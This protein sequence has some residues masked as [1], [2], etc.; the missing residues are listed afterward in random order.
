VHRSPQAAA[1]PE[2][3]PPQ[4]AP[5]E[6][7]A[8]TEAAPPEEA[9][10]PPSR[11]SLRLLAGAV[12]W[13]AGLTDSGVHR[14]LDRLEVT[15]RRGRRCVH[16]P[17]PD[18][19][20]KMA[21]VAAALGEARAEPEAVV[22]LY[23]DELTFYRRPTVGYDYAARGGPCPPARQ[24]TG[25]NTKRRVIGALDAV[26]G[27]LTALLRSRA[28]VDALIKFYKGLEEAYPAA[29]RIV[30]AQDNWP[31]HSNPRLL[32][33]VRGRRVELLW[34]PTYAPWTNPIEKVWRKLYQEV[35]HQHRLVA[36]WPKLIARV[37]RWLAAYARGSM[38]LL[39][40]V[41]LNPG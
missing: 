2:A 25:S 24:G 19:E 16:S 4:P 37:T 6:A 3:P 15:Y 17:D 13:M 38:E 10:P 11:W 31:V 12:D 23:M 40:Y 7:A 29:R 36:E 21:A 5:P 20:A 30:V 39:H 22:F 41:G 18:Y 32:E 35:L 1:P 33:A 14:L 34:L 9:P 27:R 28:D 8:P 26:T